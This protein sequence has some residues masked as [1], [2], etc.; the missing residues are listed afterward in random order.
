MKIIPAF[1]VLANLARFSSALG[2]WYST[3][4][5]GTRT[6]Q[7]KE[8]DAAIATAN[9]SSSGQVLTEDCQNLLDVLG[10][11]AAGGF[12][13]ISINGDDGQSDRWVPLK[14]NG[15]C[16][17]ALCVEEHTTMLGEASGQTAI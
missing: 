14:G 5:F 16:H 17:F 2:I 3:V 4:E 1:T 9:V 10:D 8:L 7:D 15:T 13:N 12:W 6:C 11:M